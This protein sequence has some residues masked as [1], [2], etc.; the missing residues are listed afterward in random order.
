MVTVIVVAVI[1]H[2]ACYLG[3]GHTRHRCARAHGLRPSL[4]W[5]LGRGL[6]AS[7]RLPGGFRVGHRV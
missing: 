3:A 6:W 7:V 4:Y 1:G 2:A 5:S